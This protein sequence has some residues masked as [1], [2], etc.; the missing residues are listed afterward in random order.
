MTRVHRLG[1]RLHLV[2]GQIVRPT[3]WL[4]II[5]GRDGV[6]RAWYRN[7]LLADA[8]L[9]ERLAVVAHAPTVRRILF[10]G[11]KALKYA[12]RGLSHLLLLR[13]SLKKALLNCDS[14]L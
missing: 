12:T 11:S 6:Q 8:L 1:T 2:G 14:T 13:N 10:L 3:E 4:V 9:L 5:R 7:Q